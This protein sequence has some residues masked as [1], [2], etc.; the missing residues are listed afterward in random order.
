MNEVYIIYSCT[1]TNLYFRCVKEHYNLS[2]YKNFIIF[3]EKNEM[4][5]YENMLYDNLF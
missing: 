1:Y 4:M 3:N 2:L 5:K